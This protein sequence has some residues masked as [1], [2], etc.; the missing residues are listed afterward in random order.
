MEDGRVERLGETVARFCFFIGL[1]GCSSMAAARGQTQMTI[2]VDLTD[3]PR[4]L[5]HV[6]ESLP[7]HAGVNTF[8]I[9]SGFQAKTCPRAPSTMSPG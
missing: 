7:A 5:L 6:S 9:P 4:H 8:L 3:A 1:A 2:R